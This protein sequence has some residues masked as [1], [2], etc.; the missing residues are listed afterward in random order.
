MRK[1][2]LALGKL[3]TMMVVSILMALRA[4]A[5]AQMR[6]HIDPD[7]TY[8]ARNAVYEVTISKI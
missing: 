1:C 5:C 4:C 8:Q 6:M 3:R 2:Q 7:S